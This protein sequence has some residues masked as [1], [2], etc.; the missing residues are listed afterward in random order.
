MVIEGSG[1]KQSGW[2][3][4]LTE[5][6][7][8]IFLLSVDSKLFRSHH[9]MLKNKNQSLILM[10]FRTLSADLAAGMPDIFIFGRSGICSADHVQAVHDGQ[11]GAVSITGRTHH[12]CF[13]TGTASR[14]LPSMQFYGQGG[15][16]RSL[17]LNYLMTGRSS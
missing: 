3:L 2:K 8:G 13:S 1:L 10:T 15:K 17:S 12:P 4:I 11:S 7:I 14:S 9:S 5:L 6:D 16:F